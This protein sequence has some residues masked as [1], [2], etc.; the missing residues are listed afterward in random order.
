MTSLVRE[1]RE[2]C[3]RVGS[4][5]FEPVPQR[6]C[7]LAVRARDS[8]RQGRVVFR[9]APL[10]A[11]GIDSLAYERGDPQALVETLRNLS[12][13]IG[14]L[15]QELASARNDAKRLN[16]KIDGARAKV[17]QLLTRLPE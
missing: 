6:L 17:E 1:E 15:R 10:V 16:E 3:N 13:M 5:E 2:A 14:E 4:G 8:L 12:T 11:A 7:E 9:N